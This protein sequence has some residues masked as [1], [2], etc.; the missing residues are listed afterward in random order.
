MA[1]LLTLRSQRVAEIMERRRAAVE[2]KKQAKSWATLR[3]T[4]AGFA[5]VYRPPSTDVPTVA[6]IQDGAWKGQ[7]CFIVGGGP[8]LRGFDFGRLRGE[9]VIAINRA[10]EFYPEADVMFAMD[11]R[12]Y[13][14]ITTGQL[15]DEARTRFEA[16]SGIKVW[17]LLS[18][19]RDWPGVQFIDSLGMD[20]L[21]DSIRTGLY[22]G[23]N[24][25]YAALN[26][27]VALG[28]DP[29]YLLGYD[30]MGN[31]KGGQAWYHDGYPERQGEHVYGDF[32][33]HFEKL[34]PQIA[35][36]GVQVVNLNSDSALRCFRFGDIAEIRGLGEKTMHDPGWVIISYYTKGT[37]YEQEI[38][39]L[40]ASLK[41]YGLPYH[42]FRYEP[43]GTWR[44]NLNFKSECILRAMDMFP[45]TDI[46]FVDA[47][48]VVRQY[49]VLFDELSR[50]HS[51]DL[52]AH[53]FK[54]RP[55]SGDADELLSGTLWIQNGQMGRRLVEKWHEVGLARTADTRH[56]LCLKMAIAEIEKGGE[57]VRV[58]R[59]PFAYTCI[60]DYP[61][62]YKIEPVIEH[63]QASRRLR[64]EVGYG[65][66]LIN[67]GGSNP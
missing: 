47:D 45:G 58:Y 50:T 37:G 35:E 44:G 54:Y 17:M 62:A 11:P 25:G 5:N 55:E 18:G 2:T 46:V 32:V 16:F 43:V 13:E 15:G 66:N 28:A 41:I 29:I 22:H 52:S 49:P 51:F 65:D 57:K 14:W 38:K 3:R 53:F 19:V 8:S 56:Q 39:N 1:K 9:R 60:Y 12:L 24:S 36:R 48:A 67:R 34:A 10:Y 26:L 59:H 6:P 7:R 4:G 27:A 64:R 30:C 31:G 33:G 23:N 63:F 20:G 21:T 42:I 40:E 61:Q